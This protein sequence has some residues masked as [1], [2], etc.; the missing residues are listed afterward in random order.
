[1]LSNSV[2]NF[3]QATQDGSVWIGTNGLNRWGDGHMT[4]YRGRRELSED[5]PTAQEK[6]H[7][8]GAS[9]ENVS[10]GLVGIPHSL[11][12][13]DDGRLWVSSS[14]G[15]FYFERGRFVW[16]SG[17]PRGAIISIAGDGHGNVWILHQSEG[18]FYWSPTG[19]AQE[20]PESRFAQ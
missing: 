5:V 11:G 12:L 7:V 16:V 14:D 4:V 15:L 10:S 17:L 8:S 9:T 20:V 13:D 19:G 18:I 6:L 1:G 3:V 2:A